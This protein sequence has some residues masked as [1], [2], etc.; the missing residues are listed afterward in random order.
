MAEPHARFIVYEDKAGKWRWQLKSAN[1]VDILGDSGQGY[2]SEA[3]CYEMVNWIRAN[4][5]TFPVV[6]GSLT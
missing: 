1:N 3:Y 6:A 5:H 2:V 4:A